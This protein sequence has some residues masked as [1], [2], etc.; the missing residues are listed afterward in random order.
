MG[1]VSG[2]ESLVWTWKKFVI[3]R[4]HPPFA[5]L[6]SEVMIELDED[7]LIEPDI[8]GYSLINLG[9]ILSKITWRAFT[10]FS[11]HAR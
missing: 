5:T 4:V 1:T 2:I 9:S 11:K 7:D 10:K 3:T 8:R 6:K